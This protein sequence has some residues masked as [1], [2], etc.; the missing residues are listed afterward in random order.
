MSD[1]NEVPDWERIESDYR[2]GILSMRELTEIH[3]VPAST[4]R[5][6]AR[7]FGWTRALTGIVRGRSDAIVAGASHGLGA[8]NTDD[9]IA[10]RSAEELAAVKLSHRRYAARSRGVAEKMLDELEALAGDDRDLYP[11]IAQ[12]IKTRQM[13]NGRLQQAFNHIA[14]L[15]GRI[16]ALRDLTEVMKG[17]VALERQSYAMDDASINRE[18]DSLSSLLESI[19]TRNNSAVSVVHD[20]IEHSDGSD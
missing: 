11:K 19:A 15:P 6:R 10:N 4:L 3:A 20:D 14:S 5:S 7:K 17:V 9:E 16:K 2:A 1:D 13:D 8:E 18:A 12:L